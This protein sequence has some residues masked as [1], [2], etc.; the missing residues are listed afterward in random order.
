MTECS[1]GE[2]FWMRVWTSTSS[3]KGVPPLILK[4]KSLTDYLTLGL[5]ISLWSI[6]PLV[7]P[8]SPWWLCLTSWISVNS[9]SPNSVLLLQ[10]LS[11]PSQPVWHSLHLAHHCRLT[12]FSSSALCSLQYG[13]KLPSSSARLTCCAL[14]CPV[15]C[16]GPPSATK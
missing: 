9:S 6:N 2:F 13:L 7:L 4:P 10:W 14:P 5:S 16:P 15:I 3:W 12:L 1:G 11:I 8:H